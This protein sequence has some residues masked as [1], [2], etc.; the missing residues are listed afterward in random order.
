[1]CAGASLYAACHSPPIIPTRPWLA[2]ISQTLWLTYDFALAVCRCS[3][4]GV[5]SSV[6]WADNDGGGKVDPQA[7]VTQS[8]DWGPDKFSAGESHSEDLTG[9]PCLHFER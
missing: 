8:P 4:G 6:K 5:E 9:F 3:V 1:M 7:W 2:G